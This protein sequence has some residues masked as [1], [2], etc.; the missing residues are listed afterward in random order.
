M[1]CFDTDVLIEVGRARRRPGLVRRLAQTPPDDQATTAI[2]VG[3]LLYGAR[4]LPDEQIARRAEAVLRTLVRIL[5]ADAAAAHFYAVLR[6][7]LE[8]RGERL[9]S[10]DLWIAAVCLAHDAT[11]V[12]GNVRHFARVPGLR[13]EN[14]LAEG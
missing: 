8:A 10:P 3:K 2:N 5:P 12:S 1:Y 4:R 14:W 11:L 13:V 9:A 7:W 6:A